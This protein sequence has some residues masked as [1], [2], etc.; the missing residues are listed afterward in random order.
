MFCF[1][2]I[3]L[4]FFYFSIDISLFRMSFYTTV[5][6][7][8]S[9]PPYCLGNWL[10]FLLYV[11][12]HLGS[13]WSCLHSSFVPKN[14][15]WMNIWIISVFKCVQWTMGKGTSYTIAF[16]AGLSVCPRFLFRKSDLYQKFQ[17]IIFVLL[18]DFHFV[19]T[20]RKNT[21]FRISG[22]S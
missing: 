11:K 12:L 3:L 8:F 10:T 18:N 17:T 9:V 6:Y 15:F 19:I 2:H 5:K 1:F 20:K 4:L 22:M 21:S 7:I 14:R 13:P 16:N